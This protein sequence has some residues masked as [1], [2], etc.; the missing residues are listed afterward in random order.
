M[1]RNSGKVETKRHRTRV[2]TSL[3]AQWGSRIAD[4]ISKAPAAADGLGRGVF[5]ALAGRRPLG[6]RRRAYDPRGRR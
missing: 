1:A 6:R 5:P 3:R 4:T 2:V